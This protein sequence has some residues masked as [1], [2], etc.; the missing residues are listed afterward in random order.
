MK[1]QILGFIISIISCGFLHAQ[2]Y[3][4]GT[5]SEGGTNN[6]GTIYRIDENGQNFQNVFD[7]TTST[8]GEPLGGLTLANGKLYGFTTSEGQ[9][10]GTKLGTFY[11][12]DP[13]TN[14]VT[15]IEH[16]DENSA[17]GWGISHSPTLSVDGK[18]YFASPSS[19][20]ASF[21]GILSSY[22]PSN[23]TLS[24]ALAT[25]TSTYGQPKS[26]LLEAS[27]GNL[28]VTTNSGGA[29]GFGAIVKFDKSVSSLSVLHSSVG[30]AGS[31]IEYDN[32]LNNTL[33]EASN[34]V[35]YGCSRGGGQNLNGTGIVFKI[36]K[37]GT[38]YQTLFEFSPGITDE[39]HSP[40]GGFIEKNGT[41]YSST[42]EEAVQGANSGTI[43]TVN[44]STNA[45]SFIHTLDLEGSQPK[46][47]FTESSN[48]RFYLTCS[49]GAINNGSIIEYNPLNGNVT[50]RHLFG[51]SDGISPQYD[52]LCL[53]D[54]SLVSINETSL[55]NNVVT[56]YPNPV[57]DIIN[58]KSEGGYLIKSIKILD[59]RGSE[60]FIDNSISNQSI[61]N[62]SFL[63][64]GVYLLFVN[65]NE[66]SVTRKIIKE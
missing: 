38:G 12:F 11:S 39:G 44:I 60:L 51:T 8:G 17:I 35:L 19:G 45:V 5:T 4:Y 37:D 62:T 34:G 10:V 42:P 58:I 64:S 66:G 23:S 21:D 1:K 33:F 46:G 16:L 20:L 7:F 52:E 13:L 14:T 47:V 56:T 43:F 55:L 25:Y 40:E 15:V 31:N 57:K 65:T 9:A 49:G 22:D 59:M 32:A 28:Y 48:G 41:L 53:V 30:G 2:V 24:A 36:N 54:F 63:P 29:N 6:L 18:L 3:M 27:D 26:K 61:I 50:Q